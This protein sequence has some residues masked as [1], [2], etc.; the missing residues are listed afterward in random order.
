M[1][2][3]MAYISEGG[4]LYL[5]KASAAANSL[6]AQVYGLDSVVAN[7]IVANRD[8]VI[9]TLQAAGAPDYM[10]PMV[11]REQPAPIEEPAPMPTAEPPPRTHAIG[12]ADE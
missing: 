2:R 4:N 6:V 3:V 7:E 1:K 10:I 9:R 12:I 11:E 8:A 5:D